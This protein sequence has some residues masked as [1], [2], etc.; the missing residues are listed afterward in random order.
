M[1]AVIFA[2]LLI[3]LGIHVTNVNAETVGILQEFGKYFPDFDAQRLLLVRSPTGQH[4]KG[5]VEERPLFSR[6]EIVVEGLGTDLQVLGLDYPGRSCGSMEF[7]QNA[8]HRRH[9]LIG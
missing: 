2:A 7:R 5:D 9:L 1:T 4:I 6:D 8:P 3:G